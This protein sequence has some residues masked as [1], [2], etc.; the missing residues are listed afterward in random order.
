MELQDNDSPQDH[1]INPSDFIT[2][3]K[4]MGFT[5]DQIIE[6]THD[7]LDLYQRKIAEQLIKA[8]MPESVGQFMSLQDGEKFGSRPAV[9]LEHDYIA[10]AIIPANDAETVNG[11]SAYGLA[12]LYAHH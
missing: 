7:A 1:L 3:L 11:A 4:K 12:S 2:E 8:G 10:P 9:V 6:T 5:D